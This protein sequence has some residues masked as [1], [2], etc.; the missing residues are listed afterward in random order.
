MI[1]TIIEKLHGVK[2]TGPD[3]WTGLCPAHDDTRPSLSIKLADDGRILLFCHAGCTCRE[4]MAALD[5]PMSILFPDCRVKGRGWPIPSPRRKSRPAG[6]SRPPAFQPPGEADPKI[7]VDRLRA[8]RGVISQLWEYQDAGGEACGYVLR[9]DRPDGKDIRPISRGDDGLWQIGAMPEPRPIYRLP[10]IINSNP[11][12]E[13]VFVTEGEKAADALVKVGLIATTASGGAQ[14]PRK[15]DWSPLAGRD[16]VIW[17]DADDAGQKYAREVARLVLELNPPARV[18]ILD[19][20]DFG[21]TQKE[22]AH[23][24]VTANR[25]DHHE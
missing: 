23:D 24:H 3:S 5:L 4:I 7:L 14:A 19:P 11:Q 9:W 2:K 6:P 17:P 13:P 15:T 22:D 10:Y 16:V 18:R 8:Q 20:A 25:E 12:E 21:L 1:D